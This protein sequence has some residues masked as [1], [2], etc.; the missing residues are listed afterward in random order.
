MLDVA[1][2]RMFATPSILETIVSV[3]Q[4]LHQYECAGGF[5]PRAVY[6]VAKA[7]PEVPEAGTESTADVSTPPPTSEG[8][9]ASLPRLAEA[10]ETTTTA[11]TTSTAEGIVGGHCRRTTRSV[12]AGAN[13]VRVPD[14]PAAAHEERVAPEDTTRTASPE[15]LEAEEGA[16][17][18]LLQGTE[19]GEAQALRLTRTSWASTSI[20]GDDTEDGEEVAAHNTLE[21]GL[22][23][24]CCAFDELIL[25][26]TSVSFLI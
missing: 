1:T 24:V 7:V 25:P 13:E 19:R 17:A 11:A 5:A 22:D 18:A 8:H 9:E 6:E 20:T 14:D 12:A 2:E 21:R 23:W 4:A 26:A 16:G 3:S 15:I 10:V